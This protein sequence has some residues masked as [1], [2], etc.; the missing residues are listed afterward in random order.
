MLVG[1]RGFELDGARHWI[2]LAME[3]LDAPEGG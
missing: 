1:A 3:I 2:L